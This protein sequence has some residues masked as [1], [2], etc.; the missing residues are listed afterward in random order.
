MG[1]IKE[2]DNRHA[3]HILD[4]AVDGRDPG[5]AAA[6]VFHA[7]RPLA[8]C[9][10][11]GDGGHQQQHTLSLQHEAGVV[12]EDEHAVGAEVFPQQIDLLVGVHGAVTALGQLPGQAGADDAG[13]VHAQDGVYQHGGLDALAQL[14]RH[15]LRLL[16]AGLLPG[17][18]NEIIDMTVA[19]RKMALGHAERHVA[20]TNGELDKLRFHD[21]PPLFSYPGMVLDSCLL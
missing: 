12:A 6:V 4:K 11:G 19:R 15:S 3:V 1:G 10:A 5:H 7:P 20:D 18:I 9:A 2:G 17:D 16:Q 14:L 21:V 8:H 13:A